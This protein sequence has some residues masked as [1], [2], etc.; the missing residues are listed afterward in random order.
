MGLPKVM[1]YSSMVHFKFGGGRVREVKHAADIKVGISGRTGAATAFVLEADIP[2]LLRK[3]ASAA[4]GGR[5]VF[6]YNISTIR[7]HGV[8]AL[9]RA[10]DMAQYVLSV[11]ECG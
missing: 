6:E 7:K 3:G 1:P 8:N 5:L 2:A 9:P 10:N 11:V 4:L